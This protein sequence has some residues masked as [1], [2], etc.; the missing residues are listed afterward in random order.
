MPSG[1]ECN[2]YTLHERRL[3]WLFYKKENFFG[4]HL[5]T[6]EELMGHLAV[7]A[8]GYFQVI[9]LGCIVGSLRVKLHV[10]CLFYYSGTY[11]YIRMLFGTVLNCILWTEVMKCF[12]LWVYRHSFHATTCSTVCRNEACN[13]VRLF[14]RSFVV[15]KLVVTFASLFVRLLLRS[16]WQLTL[17]G[18]SLRR[19]LLYR[20]H[21]Q[22]AY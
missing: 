12:S 18:L 7:P 10:V 4:L 22:I 5:R 2:S 9:V 6:N 8:I 21:V 13:N 20:L 16:V 19:S 1:K 17:S 3:K 15:M 14:A 11:Y